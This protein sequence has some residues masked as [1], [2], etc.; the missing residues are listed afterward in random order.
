MIGARRLNDVDCLP[1]PRHVPSFLA[2][3]IS[4]VEWQEVLHSLVNR[5]DVDWNAVVHH[6]GWY[7]AG[8][9][10]IPAVRYLS[11]YPCIGEAPPLHVFSRADH[12]YS[13]VVISS[14]L[15]P[16]GLV[17]VT[18]DKFW[19]SMIGPVKAKVVPDGAHV[20]D[21]PLSV[22]NDLT[23]ARIIERTS[24]DA[25]HA[26][27]SVSLMFA[28]R[29]RL[30]ADL[31]IPNAL[32]KSHLGTGPSPVRRQYNVWAL[33]RGGSLPELCMFRQLN[34]PVWYL[35]TDIRNCYP[36]MVLPKA[37]P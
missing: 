22:L 36:S 29:W 16:I 13:S 23:S 31:R 30:I 37:A 3:F 28:K 1:L 14:V 9:G 26:V 34:A 35:P 21:V 32:L 4:D 18:P 20:S 10:L 11:S 15:G 17:D 27:G 5:S 24:A 19:L 6:S 12:P 8:W 7:S 33:S 25:L 2:G